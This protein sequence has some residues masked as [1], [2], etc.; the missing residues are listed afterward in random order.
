MHNLIPNI[1]KIH[2]LNLTLIKL[3]GID[4]ARH[5]MYVHVLGLELGRQGM[6]IPGPG[7]VN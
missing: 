4:Q 5:L 3:H 2:S 7:L 6:A 1:F